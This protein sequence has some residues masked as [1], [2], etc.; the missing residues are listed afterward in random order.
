[1][2]TR[3]SGALQ[4]KRDPDGRWSAFRLVLAVMAGAFVIRFLAEPIMTLKGGGVVTPLGQPMAWLGV[5]IL[6]AGPIRAWM[7]RSD[8]ADVGSAIASLLSGRNARDA[9]TRS[10]NR[11]ALVDHAPPPPRGVTDDQRRLTGESEVDEP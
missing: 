10:A 11:F 5:A 3:L 6:L 2:F 7:D 1:M 9:P 4:E 8:P